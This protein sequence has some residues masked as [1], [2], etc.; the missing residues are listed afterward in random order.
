MLPTIFTQKLSEQLSRVCPSISYRNRRIVGLERRK[1]INVKLLWFKVCLTSG[2]HRY[3]ER[4]HMNWKW[5]QSFQKDESSRTHHLVSVPITSDGW[6]VDIFVWKLEFVVAIIL[7]SI[8]TKVTIAGLG[9]ELAI[10]GSTVWRTADCAS[11]HGPLN[12][13]K[14]LFYT[15]LLAEELDT[16]NYQGILQSLYSFILQG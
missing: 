11:K 2:R 10:H 6:S 16:L 1:H 9:F 4:W 13:R 5:L 14:C 8:S 3:G 12:V 15:V 7:R